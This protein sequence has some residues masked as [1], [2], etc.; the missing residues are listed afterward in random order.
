M[1]SLDQKP[2]YRRIVVRI[3][4]HKSSSE[5]IQVHEQIQ[6]SHL[7]HV[8][9]HRSFSHITNRRARPTL[10]SAAPAVPEASAALTLPPDGRGNIRTQ[11]NFARSFEKSSC[12]TTFVIPSATISEVGQY[13]NTIEPASILSRV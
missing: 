9:S 3:Q 12:G 13:S 11:I 10:P 5:F 4:K 8:A 6:P 1:S 2:F 7:A